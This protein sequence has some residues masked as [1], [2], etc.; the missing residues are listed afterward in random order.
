MIQKYDKVLIEKPKDLLEKTDYVNEFIQ[1]YENEYKL[2]LSVFHANNLFII[3]FKEVI[4][5]IQSNNLSYNNSYILPFY[6]D[7]QMQ[8]LS[9]NSIKDAITC[10]DKVIMIFSSLPDKDIF[11]DIYRN[12]VN[13]I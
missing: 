5:N 6:L 8:K 11:I 9:N 1:F 12:L 10:I 7:Q 2:T 13:L 3:N 4:E